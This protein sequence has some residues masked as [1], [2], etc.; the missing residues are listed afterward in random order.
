MSTIMCSYS[1]VYLP[2][3]MDGQLNELVDGW[4]KEGII[5]NEDL[6]FYSLV[7]AYLVKQFSLE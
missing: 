4:R 5:C 1:L 3:V 6:T 7:W 2:T